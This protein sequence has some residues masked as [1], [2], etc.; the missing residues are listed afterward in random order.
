MMNVISSDMRA[1]A[2]KIEK[3]TQIASHTG[4]M[5]F[6]IGS[7][8]NKE[9]FDLALAEYDKRTKMLAESLPAFETAREIVNA[10][11]LAKV[12]KGITPP[13]SEPASSK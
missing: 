7:D 3:G 6:S 4:A 13:E 9:T 5:F 10:I 8:F 11:Q 2:K 12:T 1:R